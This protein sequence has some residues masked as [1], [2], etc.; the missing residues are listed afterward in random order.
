M[1]HNHLLAKP[2]GSFMEDTIQIRFSSSKHLNSR[3]SREMLL[4]KLQTPLFCLVNT[5]SHSYFGNSATHS[6][7]EVAA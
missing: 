1:L 2:N 3:D 6:G 5:S 7:T 4:N